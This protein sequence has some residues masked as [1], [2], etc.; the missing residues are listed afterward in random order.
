MFPP[1][2][3]QPALHPYRHHHLS[4]SC[5]HR[6]PPIPLSLHQA[7]QHP[8]P[9]AT[10]PTW[11]LSAMAS[12]KVSVL[13]FVGTVSL[14][15]LTGASYTLS[16]FT[17]PSLLDLPSSSSAAKA[18][19]S[20]SKTATTHLNALTGAAG[21]AFLLAFALSPRG[22]RHPYL[23]YTSLFVFGSRLTDFVTPSLFGTSSSSSAAAQRRAAL[24]KARKDKAAA[25]RM[26]ASYE[27]L[28]DSHSEEGSAGLSGEELDE[29]INGEEIRGEVE[30]FVK[31]QLVQTAM[32]GIGFMMAVVGIWGDGIY[33]LA[34]SET[35]VIEL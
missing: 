20:I 4:T 16:T 23:L 26:E 32:A 14:G 3:Q 15:L 27:V 7:A 33:D 13:K 30:L 5:D 34:G 31:N 10:S 8:D 11:P 18:F 19:R 21:S 29:E 22:Y 9:I 12:K 28:G 35:L 6:S 25:K 17:I 2:S 24:A 1:A